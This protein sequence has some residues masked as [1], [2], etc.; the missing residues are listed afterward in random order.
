LKSFFENA[1]WGYTSSSLKRFELI[2]KTGYWNEQTSIAEDYEFLGRALLNSEKT[3]VL[4]DPLLT[5]T[6]GNDS[7]GSLKETRIGLAHRLIAE[8]SL[9][10]EVLRRHGVIPVTFLVAYSDRLIKTAINLYAKGES[11]FARKMGALAFQRKIKSRNKVSRLKRFVLRR[12]RWTCWFWFKLS[13]IYTVFRS[14][15][16]G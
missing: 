16:S 3:I 2:R 14:K 15:C 10:S 6:R 7:L 1:L 5:I 9:M 4:Q 12:G 11:E 13:R 8:K